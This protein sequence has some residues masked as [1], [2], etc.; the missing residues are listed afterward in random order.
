MRA[1]FLLLSDELRRQ[2]DPT[3]EMSGILEV[4]HVATGGGHHRGGSEQ[5]DTGHRH[6]FRACRTV[7][8]HFGEFPFEL[9]DALFKQAVLLDEQATSGGSDRSSSRSGPRSVFMAAHSSSIH[10]SVLTVWMTSSLLTF[11]PARE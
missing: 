1:S 6:Q 10:P 11:R 8:R 4:D 9:C 5:A 3:R 7:P 2:P